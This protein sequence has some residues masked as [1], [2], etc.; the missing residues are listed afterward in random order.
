MHYNKGQHN[1]ECMICLGWYKSPEKK[2]NWDKQIV[3][4]DCW[5]RTP[6]FLLPMPRFNNEL[7]PPPNLSP[8]TAF[9][10]QNLTVNPTA[11]NNIPPLRMSWD[12]FMTT[13]D[14]AINFTW[15]DAE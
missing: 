11:I 4:K 1:F 14:G 2:I 15:D 10:F 8:Q 6:W 9:L 13:W 3:C 7:D 12:N 5:D